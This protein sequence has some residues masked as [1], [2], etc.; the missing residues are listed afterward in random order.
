MVCLETGGTYQLHLTLFAFLSRTRLHP[1]IIYLEREQKRKRGPSS[2]S[3]WTPPYN[4]TRYSTPPGPCSF[5]S[6]P[7]VFLLPAATPLPRA[8]YC[9]ASLGRNFLLILHQQHSLLLLFYLACSLIE[10]R[11]ALH[12][13]Y[14][15][16]CLRL[17]QRPGQRSVYSKRLA[18]SQ[19]PL[20]S[21]K[22]SR[23]PHH[24]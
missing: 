4:T 20:S 10:T 18:I 14:L 9:K 5:N 2:S 16:I 24:R 3:H 21:N 6:D 22:L 17:M 11:P 15:P 12:P 19:T 7:D 13:D 1:S 8:L 23:S